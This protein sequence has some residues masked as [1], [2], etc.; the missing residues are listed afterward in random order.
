MDRWMFLARIVE[1]RRMVGDCE[2]GGSPTE[3]GRT[4][5]LARMLP[6]CGV[7]FLQVPACRSLK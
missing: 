5:G 1:N 3:T 2:G 7:L 6:R 4:H